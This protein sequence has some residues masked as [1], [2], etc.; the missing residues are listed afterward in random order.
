MAR[1]PF[2]GC[3]ED[4]T[5]RRECFRPRKGK[6]GMGIGSPSHNVCLIQTRCIVARIVAIAKRS[7]PLN[8]ETRLVFRQT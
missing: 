1:I 6:G 8:W 4:P 7:F 5:D 3:P 2:T